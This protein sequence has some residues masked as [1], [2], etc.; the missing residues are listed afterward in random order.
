MLSFLQR[1]LEGPTAFFPSAGGQ[2]SQTGLPRISIAQWFPHTITWLAGW[3]PCEC[4]KEANAVAPM[5]ASRLTP[6]RLPWGLRPVSQIQSRTPMPPAHPDSL[7]LLPSAWHPSLGHS[8]P[9]AGLS[10]SLTLHPASP[11]RALGSPEKLLLSHNQCFHLPPLIHS[12]FDSGLPVG[13]GVNPISPPM[14]PSWPLTPVPPSAF[15]FLTLT[16]TYQSPTHSQ[17]KMN[18]G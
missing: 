1:L 12:S 2:S 7:I 10:P 16:H 4:F 15:L 17:I 11:E 18:L 13:R 9:R 5:G 6:G 3:L 14:A 8:T